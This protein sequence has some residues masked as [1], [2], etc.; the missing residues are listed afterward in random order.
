[1]EKRLR[2]DLIKDGK[3]VAEIGKVSAESICR[4]VKT[5]NHAFLLEFV[6]FLSMSDQ[7]RSE[8]FGIETQKYSVGDTE[9]LRLVEEEMI[10]PKLEKIIDPKDLGSYKVHAAYGGKWDYS[11]GQRE[12]FRK[13]VLEG[14]TSFVEIPEISLCAHSVGLTTH[15]LDVLWELGISPKSGKLMTREEILWIIITL[16]TTKEY[17]DKIPLDKRC[18]VGFI[19]CHDG[20]V[21]VV[22]IRCVRVENCANCRQFYLDCEDA[23]ILD[24]GSLVFSRNTPQIVI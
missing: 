8:M 2:L 15:D 10:I 16:K 18:V 23:S 21:R 5:G 3:F 1:M 17:F 13:F 12:G 4:A 11:F 6:V 7:Q 22:T 9:H 24:V 19:R 14:M 20:V